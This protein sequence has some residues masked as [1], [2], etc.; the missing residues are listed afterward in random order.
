MI[1]PSSAESAHYCESN[2]SSSSSFE[3]YFNPLI[4]QETAREASGEEFITF[5]ISDLKAAQLRKGMFFNPDP[6]VKV[7]II[8]SVSQSTALNQTQ[9]SQSPASLQRTVLT[10]TST[11]QTT[12]FGYAREYKTFV[13][14][15]TCFPSWKNDNFVIV[16]RE[17]DRVLFEV[18]DKFARTKPSINRFLGRVLVDIQT[19]VE[20]S[21][22]NK[23]WKIIKKKIKFF[24]FYF[25]FYF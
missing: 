7:T 10:P 16:A 11:T 24:Y 14:T 21:K 20:K 22:L 3:S 17:T 23:G 5:R 2:S 9:I 25:Y 4:Q 12:L 1:F 19:L 6:Y 8:P 18:K 13:A 15:N